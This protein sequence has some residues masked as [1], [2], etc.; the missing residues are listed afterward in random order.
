MKHRDANKI[1]RIGNECGHMHDI[2]TH[3]GHKFARIDVSIRG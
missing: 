1:Q 2:Y 3:K